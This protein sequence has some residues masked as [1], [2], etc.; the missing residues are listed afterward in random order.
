MAVADAGVG[1]IF[2]AIW[3]MK[4]PS[5]IMIAAKIIMFRMTLHN[6]RTLAR[7]LRT[8]TLGTGT[9]ESISTSAAKLDLTRPARP[10]FFAK[11]VSEALT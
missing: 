4:V 1:V 11:R 2:A 9:L 7:T 6:P 10:V 5:P 3:A 8:K